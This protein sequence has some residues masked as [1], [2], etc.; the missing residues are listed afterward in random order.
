M[1]PRKRQYDPTI[2]AHIDQGKLPKYCYWDREKEHWYTSDGKHKRVRLAGSRATLSQLHRLMEDRAKGNVDTFKWLSEKY[3]ES[4]KF[5]SLARSTQRTYTRS[6]TIINTHSTKINKPLG[7]VPLNLWRNSTVQK[8]VD[9]LTVNNGPKAANEALKYARIVFK[10]GKNRDLCQH[11][12]TNDIERAKERQLRRLPDE[13]VLKLL[14]DRAKKRGEFPQHKE[15]SCPPYLW[16]VFVL[17]V[18]LRHRGIETVRLTD[19]DMLEEGIRSKRAK[20][21]RTNITRWNG[22]LRKVVKFLKEYRSQIW[23]KRGYPIPAKPEDRQLFV[24]KTGEPLKKS[25]L[26]AAYGRF[27][28]LAIEDKVITEE[29]RFGMHD[30]KRRGTTDTP[31]TRGDKAQA[32]GHKDEATVDIYDFSE[33]VVEPV[34]K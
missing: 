11:N 32:T 6:E 34:S 29:Q 1:V 24:G 16:C 20:G 27:I 4:T 12:P 23:E 25:G 3:K 8:L 7:G 33:T 5:T 30:L 26:N 15:G 22:K 14:I 9:K 28:R 31:G 18:E 21:S 19:A 10:W 13:N 2:P 17:G